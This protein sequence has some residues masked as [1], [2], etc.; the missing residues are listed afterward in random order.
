VVL[1]AGGLLVGLL[2]SGVLSRSTGGTG[3]AIPTT[4]PVVTT[5]PKA[6]QTGAEASPFGEGDWGMYGGTPDQ[7]RHSALSEITK[8]NVNELGRVANIDFRRL[9]PAVPKGQQSFPIVVN[10]V[11]Y[12]TTSNNWVFAVDGGSGKILWHWKP[13]NTGVFANYGVNANRGVLMAPGREEEWTLSVQHTDE[14]VDRY[15]A[16]FEELAQALARA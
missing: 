2:A 11:I 6:P 5:N 9:Y 16:V 12:V 14:A 3:K 13:K 8:Q 7:I 15:V 10:G 1:A 4:A